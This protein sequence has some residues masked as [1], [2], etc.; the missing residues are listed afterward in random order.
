MKFPLP[1]T[2]YPGPCPI[3]FPGNHHQSC[4]H[5]TWKMSG[6]SNSQANGEGDQTG[7]AAEVIRIIQNPL[8][9]ECRANWF[10]RMEISMPSLAK[11][12]FISSRS[13]IL[14]YA[15]LIP[16]NNYFLIARLELTERSTDQSNDARGIYHRISPN[17]NTY[18]FGYHFARRRIGLVGWRGTMWSYGSPNLSRY[19]WSQISGMKFS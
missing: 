19:S 17:G 13:S 8:Q 10:C 3:L 5:S 11:L 18:R 1:L 2:R 7:H 15:T 9:I 6:H 4:F 14:G 16:R 12:W